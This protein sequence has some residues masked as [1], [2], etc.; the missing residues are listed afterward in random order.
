MVVE[1]VAVLLLAG[2]SGA[3]SACLDALQYAGHNARAVTEWESPGPIKRELRARAYESVEIAVVMCSKN[4]RARGV[5]AAL[6]TK[7]RLEQIREVLCGR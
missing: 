4:R 7:L 1:V 3:K 5:L 2:G 6:G